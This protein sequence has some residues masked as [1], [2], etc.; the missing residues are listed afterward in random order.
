MSGERGAALIGTLVI[1]FAVVLVVGQ[2][3]L[4]LGR[5]GAASAEAAEVAAYAA[6][7]G[8]RYGGSNEAAAVARRLLPEAEVEVHDDGV[9][10]TVRVRLTVSLIGPGSAPLTRT[11]TGRAVSAISPYRSRS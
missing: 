11:V 2:S 9:T 5:L 8:A 3:L 6:Q 1:G 4:A 7:Q 10:L